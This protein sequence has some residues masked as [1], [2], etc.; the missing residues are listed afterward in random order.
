MVET[1][2]CYT[3]EFP[4]WLVF[5]GEFSYRQLYQRTAAA[6]ARWANNQPKGRSIETDSR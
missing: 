5:R 4:K 1:Q 6:E 2:I 3:F